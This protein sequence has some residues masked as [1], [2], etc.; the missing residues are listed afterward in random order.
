ME[1]R[2]AECMHML[3]G[4]DKCY[5]KFFFF[6]TEEPRFIEIKFAYSKNAPILTSINFDKCV[7]NL[8][9]HCHTKDR[10]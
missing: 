5:L 1:K 3:S 9:D 8:Y 10:H 7:I 2:K 4:T 6:L